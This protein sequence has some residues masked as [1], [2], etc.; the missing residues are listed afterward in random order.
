MGWKEI[1]KKNHIELLKGVFVGLATVALWWGDGRAC[2]IST[3]NLIPL[4]YL[5][6]TGLTD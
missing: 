5:R 2:L 6:L 1:Q 3:L 4:D